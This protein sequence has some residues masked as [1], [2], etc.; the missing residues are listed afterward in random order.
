MKKAFLFIVVL[1]FLFVSCSKDETDDRDQF[2]GTW[3]G[4]QT[5]SIPSLYYN[6]TYSGTLI[7]TKSSG[8]DSKILINSDGEVMSATVS[9]KSYIYEEYSYTDYSGSSP[10]TI[11]QRG[12]GTINGNTITESGT[13]TFFIDGE[14]YPGTWSTTLTKL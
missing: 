10:I 14:T 8:D 2:V 12:S 5:L 13:L 3:K 7:I 6:E 11:T 9:G 1:G 4:T